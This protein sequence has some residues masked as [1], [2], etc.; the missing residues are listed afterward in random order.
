MLKATQTLH[1]SHLRSLA[2]RMKIRGYSP[3]LA[4]WPARAHARSLGRGDPFRATRRAHCR[5]CHPEHRGLA[6]GLEGL[7]DNAGA[8][9]GPLVALLFVSMLHTSLR[10]VFLMAL[11]PGVLALLLF[12]LVRPSRTSS[13]KSSERE[14]SEQSAGTESERRA[15]AP[16]VRPSLRAVGP[17]YWRYLLVTQGLCWWHSSYGRWAHSSS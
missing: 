12:L 3:C 11:L 1:T 5:L 4:H 17:A 14:G 6:L 10:S 9:I 8:Y 13:E 15:G 7:G 16:V 2:R